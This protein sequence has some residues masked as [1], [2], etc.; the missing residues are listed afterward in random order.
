MRGLWEPSKLCLGSQRVGAD[1][2]VGLIDGV[3]T[4]QMNEMTLR[5]F[6]VQTRTSILPLQVCQSSRC[7]W[8]Q[9]LHAP[10]SELNS[11]IWVYSDISI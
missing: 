6:S 10:C 5:V 3:K 1:H 9:V 2:T 7:H 11:H 4:A 8:R